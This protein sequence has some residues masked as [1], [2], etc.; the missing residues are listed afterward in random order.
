MITY[1]YNE[2]YLCKLTYINFAQPA[3]KYLILSAQM[4]CMLKPTI[5]HLVK[6]VFV[7]VDEPKFTR[8][9]SVY[10]VTDYVSII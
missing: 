4:F 9:T 5:Q 3:Y 2:E 7:N 10:Y 8:N 1:T 6:Q